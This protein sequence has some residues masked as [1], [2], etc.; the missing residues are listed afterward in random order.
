MTRFEKIKDMSP[1]EFAEYI[2]KYIEIG[3]PYTCSAC[4]YSDNDCRPGTNVCLQGF[5]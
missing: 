1:K 2:N 4:K 3:G 5:V